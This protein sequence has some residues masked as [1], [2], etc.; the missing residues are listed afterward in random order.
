MFRD[1]ERMQTVFTGIAA[2][3]LFG[4]SIAY[5][6]ASQGGDGLLVSGSYFPVLQLQPALGRLLAIAASLVPGSTLHEWV[7]DGRHLLGFP[8]H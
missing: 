2:H 3:N 8:C 5:G 4:A 6:G 7:H 1:L